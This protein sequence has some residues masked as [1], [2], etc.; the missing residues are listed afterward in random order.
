[1]NATI[2]FLCNDVL[3]ATE[4]DDGETLLSVLRERFG[5]FSAKD[6][7]A[8]QGQCGCCTVLV[9]GAARVAC[10]TPAAR[11]D[12][13]SITTLEG[14]DADRVGHLVDR[15]LDRG[16]SQCGFCTPGILMRCL[17]LVDDAKTP[18]VVDLD[19]ALAAHLCRCTGWQTIGEALRNPPVPDDMR[20]HRDLDLATTR[21]TLESRVPQDVGKRVMLGQ[22]GFADDRVPSD[23]VVAVPKPMDSGVEGVLAEGCEWVVGASLYEARITA[24]KVQGRRTTAP[25]IAPIAAPPAPLGG[26]ALATCFVEPGYL[27]PDAS[28]CAVDG[29]AANPL[30]NGGAFG[31]KVDSIAARAATSLAE[32]LP[33]TVRVELSRED[34][35]RLGPKRPPIGATACLNG[36]QLSIRGRSA[37]PLV[38]GPNLYGINVVTDIEHVPLLGPPVSNTLRAPWAEAAVLLEGALDAADFDRSGAV[39]DVAR[40][41]L[42]DVCV[43]S[44][45][46][47]V[48]GVHIE[49]NDSG[50]SIARVVVRA[51]A[52][53][54]LDEVVARSYCIGAVHMALGWVLSEGLT[55]DAS[56]EVHDLTIRS[57]GIIRP[58][59]MPHVEVQF[60]VDERQACAVSDAVFV[61]TAAATW[62]A[63]SR[64]DG[65]RPTQFPAL[66]SS[67][68]R[69]IRK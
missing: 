19:R 20:M 8:P 38:V 28:W 59:K 46:G 68:S 61:A 1:M 5:I 45:D 52:G 55:V 4:I 25:L 30:A 57:F 39:D 13:R 10:V 29:A 17:A 54:V 51:L 69:T 50:D 44:P 26:V 12:G 21:A 11:I 42:L 27:E 6:G 37:L 3:V 24:A 14:I 53:E 47:G 7:C 15:F 23:A 56:G 33:C 48:A 34:V 67:L 2:E 43:Q 65:I 49:L 36:S 32:L 18:S 64:T 62:N 60:I 31:G 40:Q 66:S 63:V 16:A 35:V 22:G 41:A 58:K 9:D